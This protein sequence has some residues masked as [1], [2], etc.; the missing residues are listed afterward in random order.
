MD[1]K[2]ARKLSDLNNRWSFLEGKTGEEL[3]EALV[4]YLEACFDIWIDE[5]ARLGKT[6][7]MVEP[8]HSIP[9]RFHK[10]KEL[11]DQVASALQEKLTAEEK[12][13]EVE[14]DRRDKRVCFQVSW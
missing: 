5:R 9:V 12:G 10:K 7:L 13:F 1:A 11:E 2:D 6:T 8:F 4:I 14:W 3:S